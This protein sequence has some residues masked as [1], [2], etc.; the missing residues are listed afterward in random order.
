M[1]TIEGYDILKTVLELIVDEL[2]EKQP[3]YEVISLRFAE[4]VFM[5][6]VRQYYIKKGRHEKNLLSDEAIYK[7]VNYIHKNL[8]DNLSLEKLSRLSGLSR[9]LF[10]DRFKKAT[11]QTP[12]QYIKTWRMTK[13]KYF[14]KYSELSLNE[15]SDAIGYHSSSAFSRVFKEVFDISPKKFQREQVTSS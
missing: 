14:L 12:F 15:I 4:I 1:K 2:T 10:I 3:G 8:D 5:S 9:T 6:T 11:N 7:A 13:A